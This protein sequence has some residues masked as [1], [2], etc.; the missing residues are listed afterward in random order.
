MKRVL[1]FNGITVIRYYGFIPL[2][3]LRGGDKGWVSLKLNKMKAKSSFFDEQLVIG[4]RRLIIMLCQ[5]EFSLTSVTLPK[6]V[7]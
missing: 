4:D 6:D 1:R 7:A 5:Q 2:N 3:P